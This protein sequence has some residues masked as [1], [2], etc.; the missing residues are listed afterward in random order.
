MERVAGAVRVAPP[1]I[2]CVGVEMLA[3]RQLVKGQCACPCA[4][5]AAATCQ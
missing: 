1:I 2:L 4:Q 5:V 3:S